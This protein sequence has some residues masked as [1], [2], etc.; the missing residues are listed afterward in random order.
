[1]A[2]Q[3]LEKRLNLTKVYH[4]AYEPSYKTATLHFWTKCNL[5]CRGCFC[6]YEQSYF[7]LYDDPVSRLVN[8]APGS[9]PTRFL[10]IEEVVGLLKGLTINTALLMGTEPSLDPELSA[11]TK[12]LH[13]EIGSFNILM[14]NGLRLVD[15][16]H[17]DLVLLGLKAYSED[18][19]L[20]YTGKSNKRILENFATIYRSG[21]KLQ[22][23]SLVIPD[24]IDA[25]EIERIASFIAGVD[26]NIPLT[27]HAYF[28]VPDSPWLP[29]TSEDVKAAVTL[30]R[31]HLVNVPYRTLD[32][33]RV[34]EPAVSIV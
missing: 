24:Y 27:I 22:V 17:I 1:M 7:N 33:K 31:K 6:R 25:H 19:H 9:P 12:T 34:G 5:S 26:R 28:P 23:I 8:K 29:A 13:E 32:L 3:T 18:I 2:T 16:E 15:M 20:D 4:I 30:A 14:T 11:L 10:S 21:K